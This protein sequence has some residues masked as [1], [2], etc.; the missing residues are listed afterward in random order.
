M[1]FESFIK[2]G[3]VKKSLPDQAL[4]SSLI[5]CADADL[6][7]LNNLPINKNSARKVMI[8]YYDTLRSLLE[9]IASKEGYKVYSH[10]A[11]VYF[12]IDKNESPLA[13]KFDRFRKLRNKLNY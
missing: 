11:F 2:Q 8:S 10:E 7:F 4:I 6:I 1:N 12:L 5:K 3:K 9:A 13:Q